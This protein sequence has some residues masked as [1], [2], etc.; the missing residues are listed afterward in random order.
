L[1][2][3]RLQTCERSPHAAPYQLRDDRSDRVIRHGRVDS[4]LLNHHAAQDGSGGGGG[5]VDG[6]T[7]ARRRHESLERCTLIEIGK[8]EGLE[9]IGDQLRSVDCDPKRFK[10]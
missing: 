8:Q 5:V 4:G 3:V 2:K 7:Q 6:V 1:S 9:A 10:A